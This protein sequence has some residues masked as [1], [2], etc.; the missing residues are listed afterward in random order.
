M[1]NVQFV[2]R[3]MNNIMI[4]LETM[5]TK[6][7]AAII[8]IGAVEFD[9]ETQKL[10][11]EFY[12]VVDLESAVAVGGVIDASTVLWWMKQSDEARA[13]FLKLGVTIHFALGAFS[14]WCRAKEE[15]PIIWGNGATFDNVILRSAYERCGLSVPWKYSD[16]RCFRT[17]RALYLPIDTSSWGGVKHNALDDAKWQ[18]RYLLEVLKK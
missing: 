15:D 12:L 8:A 4:D 17:V 2:G 5:G 18:A 10:G 16:D 11:R 13:E 14:R 1:K 6:N 7:D 9:V 3:V